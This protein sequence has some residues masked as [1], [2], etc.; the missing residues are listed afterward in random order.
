MKNKNLERKE[1]IKKLIKAFE[2]MPIHD[3]RSHGNLIIKHPYMKMTLVKNT[4][5]VFHFHNIK[6]DIN[7][8]KIDKEEL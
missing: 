3:L 6:L 5:V 8:N 4:S 2:A 1:I 7:G